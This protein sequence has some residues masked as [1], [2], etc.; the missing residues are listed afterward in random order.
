MSERVLKSD[1][2]LYFV[3]KE[4]IYRRSVGAFEVCFELEFSIKASLAKRIQ[5]D[6]GTLFQRITMARD[7]PEKFLS[8]KVSESGEQR[9]KVCPTSVREESA[10]TWLCR[11]K[12]L[13]NPKIK[14]KS[15]I[16]IIQ[17]KHCN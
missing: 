10:R 4:Q 7:K 16:I 14:I 12:F 13:K 1:K 8:Q 3:I 9:W 17:P 15:V 6:S 5:V 2:Q 11:V